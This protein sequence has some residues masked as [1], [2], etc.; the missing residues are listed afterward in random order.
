LGFWLYAFL[1]SAAFPEDCFSGT[2]WLEVWIAAGVSTNP[3]EIEVSPLYHT[4][5]SASVMMS[6]LFAGAAN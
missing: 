3:S 4:R 5:I 6:R 1:N 2:Q